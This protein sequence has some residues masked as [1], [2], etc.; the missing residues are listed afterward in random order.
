VCDNINTHVHGTPVRCALSDC[1]ERPLSD[2]Q[3]EIELLWNWTNHEH[4]QLRLFDH[5]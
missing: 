1:S 5:N 2:R 4:K 3:E